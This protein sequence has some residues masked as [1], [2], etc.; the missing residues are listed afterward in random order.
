MLPGYV[1]QGKCSVVCRPG[2]NAVCTWRL[3]C[4]H[5]CSVLAGRCFGSLASPDQGFSLVVFSVLTGH[6]YKAAE[7]WVEMVRSLAQN[8]C[9]EQEHMAACLPHQR[10]PLSRG[11]GQRCTSSCSR[12][13]QNTKLSWHSGMGSLVRKFPVLLLD[14]ICFDGF[15]STGM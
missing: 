13:P 2:H 10:G 14:L 6:T 4:E 12:G 15:V 5:S 9:Q 1:L 7:G 8:L 3:E 11:E